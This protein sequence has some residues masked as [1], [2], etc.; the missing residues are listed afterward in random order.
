M[1]R[2]ITHSSAWLYA[3]AFL[4][5]SVPATRG[6]SPSLDDEQTLHSAGLS[7][8]G[9][10]LLAFFHARACTDIDHDRLLI[11]LRQFAA[12]AK[13]ERH[14]ATAELLGLG[15]LALPVLRQAV[16]DLYREARGVEQLPL[17]TAYGSSLENRLT[18][19]RLDDSNWQRGVGSFEVEQQARAIG[20]RG[21][22]LR[23]AERMPCR[24]AD[25]P[26]VV[27]DR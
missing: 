14:S 21:A 27:Q 6:Q 10:A 19:E 9:P 8:D 24:D 13:E 23:Q 20:E 12:D 2:R 17:L 26:L 3:L 7:A 22:K 25:L 15:P 16:G 18:A 1:D 11:L 5:L 4:T